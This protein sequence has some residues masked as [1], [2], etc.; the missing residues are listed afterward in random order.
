MTAY[1]GDGDS[2][3]LTAEVSE[4]ECASGREPGRFLR[5]P[6]V[7]ETVDSVT[8]YWTSEPS[9]GDQNCQGNPSVERVIELKEPLGT[10]TVFDGLFY[11]PRQVRT[12]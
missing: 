12:R 3:R 8:V 2:T 7:V 4:R 6:F 9:T 5:E 10:R 1:R 11:P